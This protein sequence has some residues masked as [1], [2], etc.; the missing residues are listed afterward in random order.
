[1]IEITPDISDPVWVKITDSKEKSNH[2]R[3]KTGVKN[4]KR[5]DFSEKKQF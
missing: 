5:Q 4:E 2:F 3:R 1:L